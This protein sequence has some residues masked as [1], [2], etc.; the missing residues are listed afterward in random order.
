[1]KAIT[2]FKPCLLAC[3]VLAGAH[4]LAGPATINS[5]QFSFMNYSSPPAPF[6]S[7]LTGSSLD[8]APKLLPAPVESLPAPDPAPQ[9]IMPV[10]EVFLPSVQDQPTTA[11]LAEVSL[12]TV[13]AAA[14][15][16]EPA[17]LALFGLGLAG[18]LL[19]RREGIHG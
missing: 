5:I 9:Q 7:G 12:P 8:S 19:R 3:S 10:T 17:S 14:V 1:M 11:P 15:I 2:L 4:A 18:L 16:P 6:Y 13:A